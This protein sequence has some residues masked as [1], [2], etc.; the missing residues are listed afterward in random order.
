MVKKTSFGKKIDNEQYANIMKFLNEG[1]EATDKNSTFTNEK[2]CVNKPT[3]PI[4]HLEKVFAKKEIFNLIPD[5]YY[6][7]EGSEANLTSEDISLDDSDYYEEEENV[8]EMEQTF[9]EY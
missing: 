8:E 5:D 9:E 1:K 4:K 2:E 3:S 7:Q 6:A